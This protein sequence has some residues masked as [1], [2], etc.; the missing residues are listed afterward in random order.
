MG[1]IVVL[2]ILWITIC[3]G[4]NIYDEIDPNT[5]EGNNNS[6]MGISKRFLT[7]IRMFYMISFVS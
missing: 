1:A 2:V 4:K 7:C 6:Q 5:S 3:N